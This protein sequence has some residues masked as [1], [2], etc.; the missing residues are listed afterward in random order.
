ML[1]PCGWRGTSY[2]D[3]S[4]DYP[5]AHRDRRLW[6][7]GP[8]ACPRAGH[9]ARLRAGGWM[10]SDRRAGARIRRPVPR[11]H[12]LRR[13]RGAA[14][15]GAPGCGGDRHQQRHPRRAHDPGGRGRRARDLLREADGDLHGR[16]PGHGGDLPAPWGSAG[17]Q[18]SA[19]HAAG[20]PDDATFDRGRRD[21]RGRADLC[22]LCRRS[23]QRWYPPD[24][25]DPPPGRRCRGE[26]GLRPGVPCAPRP[27]RA[28]QHRLSWVWRLALRSSGGNRRPG[29][30]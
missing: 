9:A 2:H 29:G 4:Y 5:F 12:A 26:L 7:H 17:G 24:R 14:G 27:R 23:A 15:C 6:R 10:R 25:H 22:E 20:V 11:R 30:V 16:W 21:R 13:L 18:P 8:Q 28:A 3:Y 1:I 19:P